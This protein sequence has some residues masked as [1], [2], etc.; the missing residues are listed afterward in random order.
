MV[1]LEK[2]ST[3]SPVV[4]YVLTVTH[5]SIGTSEEPLWCSANGGHELDIFV[6]SAHK[7]IRLDEEVH[8]RIAWESVVAVKK[9]NTI[10]IVS[11]SAG[12]A[13]LN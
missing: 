7:V 4:Y 2:E 3:E 1:A 8:T 6:V 9:Y 13:T 10:K 11:A 12:D 5:S